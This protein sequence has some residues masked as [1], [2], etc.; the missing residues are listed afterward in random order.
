MTPAVAW[1][2][3]VGIADRP[4]V[5]GKGGSLGELTQ[6]GIAVPPGFVV[7]TSAFETFL[8]A[9]E[10]REDVRGQ[11]EALDPNDLGAATRLSEQLRARVMNEPMPPAVEQA[12]MSAMDELCPDGQPVA[13][14][15]SATTEDADDAS[16]AGLQDTFLW[17]L[18]AQDMAMKVRECWGSLYSVESMIYRR[19][20]D[21]PED[22]VA[23][24]VVIQQMVDARC[25]GVMF[26]RSPTTGDKSVITIEG[27]WGLGSSVVSGEVTPDKWVVGKITGEISARDISDKH[28]KQVPAPGGGIVE[29]E[30]EGDERTT[31]CLTD[32]D[33]MGL[34]EVGRKVERHYGKAQDIEWALDKDGNILLLQS[35]PETVW[36]AKDVASVTKPVDNPLAH[37]MNIFGGRK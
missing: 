12:I 9:L 3:D 15:S 13:V 18:T 17:V 14:R 35:R 11:V 10:A 6:A 7:T 5:G 33:L 8:A 19:K 23:M 4:T 29:I 22:G 20:Q 16:F 21:F 37:V 28:A 31:P 34:R 25:A 36:S 26:T 30:L 32:E 1:F 24:A 27:A 2:A